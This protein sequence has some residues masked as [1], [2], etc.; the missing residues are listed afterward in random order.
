MVTLPPFCLATGLA[1]LSDLLYPIAPYSASVFSFKYT[2]Y[3]DFA[4]SPCN[5]YLS[6]CLLNPKGS[7]LFAE[8]T[9]GVTLRKLEGCDAFV[10]VEC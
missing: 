2:P 8:Y 9:N 6:Y 7:K 5:V 1:N 3:P 10:C 4:F